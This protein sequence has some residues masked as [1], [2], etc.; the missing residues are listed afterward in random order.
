MELGRYRVIAELAR[1][2]MGIV[3]LARMRGPGGFEKLVVVKQLKPEL[4]K[5]EA[6]QAMF[7]DEA[8]LAARLSHRNIV[9][10]NE[11]GCDGGDYFMALE[12]LEGCSLHQARRRV[13]IP[14]RLGLRVLAG[15]LAGLHHAHEQRDDEG[16]PLGIV[17]RDVSPQN[18]FLTY[19]GQVKLLDFGVAKSKGRSYETKAGVLKGS[20]GYMSPDHVSGSTID[21]RADVFAAG[22][23]LREMLV[24]DR[25]WGDLDD[26]D[27]VK[28]LIVGDLPP[29]PDA[30]SIPPALRAICEKAMMPRRADRYATAAEM[31]EAIEAWLDENDPRG[32]LGELGAILERAFAAERASFR[33]LAKRAPQAAFDATVPAMI[34]PTSLPSSV[35]VTD[36]TAEPMPLVRKNARRRTLG[37]LAAIALVVLGAAALGVSGVVPVASPPAALAAA[38]PAPPPIAPARGAEEPAAVVA[39]VAIPAITPAELPEP[40]DATELPP[41]PYEDPAD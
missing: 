23:L 28:K 15:V 39:A 4:A 1:G 7:L 10:T 22:L 21:R 38:T 26:V 8:R 13:A 37:S 32:S 2:G 36:V 11:V 29:F 5:E 6:F 20:V 27:V 34:D 3:H 30:A 19:D 17:H 18:V 41:N 31:R 16:R 33:A 12:L 35:L 9:Q 40:D 14:L 25:F 24:G